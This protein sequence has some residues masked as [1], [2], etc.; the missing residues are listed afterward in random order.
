VIE[1]FGDETFGDDVVGDEHID[2]SP[3]KCSTNSLT[4]S[5]STGNPN[6]SRHELE[7]FQAHPNHTFV[8]RGNDLPP[9]V[10]KEVRTDISDSSEAL[11]RVKFS[12]REPIAAGGEKMGRLE[13]P[14]ADKCKRDPVEQFHRLIDVRVFEQGVASLS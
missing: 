9:L 6:A 13:A 10:V 5:K 3:V 2:Q 12:R 8:L 14:N 7:F 1:T 4:F 11:E